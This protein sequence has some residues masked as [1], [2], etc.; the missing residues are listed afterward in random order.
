[1]TWDLESCLTISDRQLKRFPNP[2]IL[3]LRIQHNKSDQLKK[4]LHDLCIYD[5]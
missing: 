1:M 2:A 5:S 4:A 3:E